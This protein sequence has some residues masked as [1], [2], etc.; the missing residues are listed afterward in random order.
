MRKGHAAQ[1]GH[2]FAWHGHKFSALFV[3]T[4]SY[5]SPT[6]GCQKSLIKVIKSLAINLVL[7]NLYVLILAVLQFCLH[8][9]KMV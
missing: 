7:F 3:T 8:M 6:S 4:L 9:L 1:R 2:T 5:R